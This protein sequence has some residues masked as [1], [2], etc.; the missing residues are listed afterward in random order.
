MFFNQASSSGEGRWIIN[1]KSLARFDGFLAL[2]KR[3]L[4]FDPFYITI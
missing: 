1:N 2:A 3:I 4:S